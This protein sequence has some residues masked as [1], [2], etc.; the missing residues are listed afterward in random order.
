MIQALD[1]MIRFERRPVGEDRTALSGQAD[2]PWARRQRQS[3][4]LEAVLWIV[5]AGS[6]RRDLPSFFGKWNSV[7]KLCRDWVKAG[8]FARLF[9]ACSD[10]PDLEYAIVDAT[11]VKVHRHGQGAKEGLKTRPSGARRAAGRPKSSCSPTRS[12][13]CCASCC[14]RA[15]LRHHRRSSADRWGRVRALIADKSYDS[16]SIIAEL[17][18]R[19]ANAVISRHPRRAQPIR[20]DEEMH[21][22]RHLIENLFCKLR[23]FK[24]IAM[25]SDKTDNSHSANL[26]LAAAVINSR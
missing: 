11:I 22:W 14:S 13:I 2:G 23:E 6:P 16:D 10:E 5:R 19:G 12:A 15:S 18:A 8:V 26:F 20:I 21:K 1:G 25:R 4:F 3:L 24:R 17:N 9:E 7:F